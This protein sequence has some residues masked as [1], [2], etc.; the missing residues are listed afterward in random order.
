MEEK[1]RKDKEVGV[2]LEIKKLS[3]SVE[4]A[5]PFPDEDKVAILKDEIAQLKID[6]EDNQKQID[7]LKAQIDKLTKEIDDLGKTLIDVRNDVADSQKTV[8]KLE[9][10]IRTTAEMLKLISSNISLVKSKLTAIEKVIKMLTEAI[11]EHKSVS[12]SYNKKSKELMA[13]LKSG[14][15]A[16]IGAPGRAAIATNPPEV[17]LMDEDLDIR[18]LNP[19]GS[20]MEP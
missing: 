7:S 3:L 19:D 16:P 8:D 1:E 9:E 4:E 11:D 5:R 13:I 2:S 20:E 15:C 18:A 10:S 12:A 6:R 14:N 17:E